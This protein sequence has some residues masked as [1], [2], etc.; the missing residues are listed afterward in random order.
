[1]KIM[2]LLHPLMIRGFSV[3]PINLLRLKNLQHNRKQ[4]NVIKRERKRRKKRSRNIR[5]S[6]NRED[7]K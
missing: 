1:M 6:R 3:K 7:L 2:M 4:E 5:K